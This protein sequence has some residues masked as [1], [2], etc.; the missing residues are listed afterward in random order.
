M[1]RPEGR[2]SF[3]VERDGRTIAAVVHQ[4]TG[5]RF[6]PRSRE[7]GWDLRADPASVPSD[8]PTPHGQTPQTY[9]ARIASE[10]GEAYR[11]ALGGRPPKP[12]TEHH[13]FRH[14]SLPVDVAEAIDRRG[15]SR[16]VARLVRADDGA[17]G[18]VGG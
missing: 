11:R 9:Y 3:R 14:L 13:Q 15:G 17:D 7:D 16:Y 6:V 4:E 1:A 5:I 18:E 12:R 10:A 8:L 2:L